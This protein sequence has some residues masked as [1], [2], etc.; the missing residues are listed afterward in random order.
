MKKQDG[1]RELSDFSLGQQ[2]SYDFMRSSR[3]APVT[4]FGLF[5][6]T[7]GQTERSLIIAFAVCALLARN[8]FTRSRQK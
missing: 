5:A 2:G 6:S 3:R 1:G 4:S 8:L 7:V